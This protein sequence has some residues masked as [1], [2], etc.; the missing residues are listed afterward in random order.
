MINHAWL[1]TGEGE[2]LKPEKSSPVS[3]AVL[4]RDIEAIEVPLYN[5]NALAGIRPGQAAGEEV[6]EMLPW[7]NAKEGDFAVRFDG[8]SMEPR[9][10]D[11]AYVLLRPCVADPHE[12]AYGHIHLVVTDD[13]VALRVIRANTDDIRSLLLVSV[14]DVYPPIAVPFEEIR[15]IYRAISTLSTL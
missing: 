13:R 7:I 11:G 10:H 1:P 6:E 5:I 8:D 2:M 15:H 4:V 14:N 12:L 9:V 3:N